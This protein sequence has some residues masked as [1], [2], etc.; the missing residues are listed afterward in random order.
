[1]IFLSSLPLLTLFISFPSFVLGFFGNEFITGTSA[2]VFL[3]ISQF[4][5]AISG[6][7]GYILQMTGKE[8]V[9]QYIVFAATLINITL[10]L[11][12]IPHYGINGA[13]FASMIS[14]AFWNLIS[15]VYIKS[16]LNFITIYLPGFRK[17][18]KI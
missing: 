7:V 8:N 13:A 17:A 11:L 12:L 14:L 4:V 6:S 15:I 5:N 18:G 16:F 3:S 2:L 10:N 1:M 9:F